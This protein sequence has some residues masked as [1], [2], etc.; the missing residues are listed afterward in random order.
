MVEFLEPGGTLEMVGA[1]VRE[2]VDPVLPLDD[3]IALLP[4]LA[5][6]VE[7]AGQPAWRVLDRLD[8]AYEIVDGWCASPTIH[9]AQLALITSLQEVANTYG[10]VSIEDL[11]ILNPSQS[12]GAGVQSLRSWLS[13]CGYVLEG[14]NVFTRTQSVGDRA[15]SILSVVGSPMA[16]QQILDKFGVE[17]NLGSL[18]N[19][20]SHD[21]R[22]ERVDRD[23]WALKEWGLESY[24]GVRSL[25]REEV[26]RG[27]GQIPMD[28]LIERI[29]GKYSVTASSVVTYASSPP[30]E[31]KSGIVRFVSADHA[32]RKSPERTRRLYRHGKDWLYRVRVTTEHLRGSGSVAPIAIASIL[33]LEPGG[34]RKLKSALGPQSVSWSGPQPA[35]GTIRRFLVE[36]DTAI[37]SEVFLVLGDD[38]S[39]S[40]RPVEVAQGQQLDQA[41]ALVGATDQ[42]SRS[43]PRITF[44]RA[45]GL[46]DN[47]PAVSVIGAYRD[48]GDGD[49]ADLLV[50]VKD[51]LV[52]GAVIAR[53]VPSTEIREILDLL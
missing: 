38:G 50:S 37:G 17:R 18:K 34:V 6:M 32:A 53:P 20:M 7:A 14:E 41:L 2:L 12:G 15:A 52:D 51:Q 45:A 26:A 10:V 5:H 49:I 21:D 4:S 40:I 27:G 28:S 1:A 48:R 13:Y 11:G 24:G 33:D 9:G 30:F 25:V 8:D 44:A 31:V 23:R 29:T 19:A 35:F 47:S 39:F 42:Q 22:L 36:Q 16:A 43:E 3:L 46:P